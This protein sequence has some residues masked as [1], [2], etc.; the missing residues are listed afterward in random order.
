MVIINIQM[1]RKKEIFIG[2][3]T[4]AGTEKKNAPNVRN[5]EE[6]AESAVKHEHS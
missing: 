4:L 2:G 6:K 1:V 5:C 3:N